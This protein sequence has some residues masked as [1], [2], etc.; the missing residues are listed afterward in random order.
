M[1]WDTAGSCS[2]LGPHHAG[3]AGNLQLMLGGLNGNEREILEGWRWTSDRRFSKVKREMAL[4]LFMSFLGMVTRILGWLF[5]R[6]PR[7][8]VV[9]EH[10]GEAGRQ[11]LT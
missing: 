3:R 7:W 6:E 11:F 2:P 8:P 5:L 1:V 10:S 4:Y 9:R